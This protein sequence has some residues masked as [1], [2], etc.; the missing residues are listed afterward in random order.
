MSRRRRNAKTALQSQ[1]GIQLST[2]EEHFVF[3]YTKD[4]DHRRA[5]EV[6]GMHPDKG[7]ELIGRENV[8]EAV[9]IIYNMQMQSSELT[10]ETVKEEMYML[11]KL[12]LQKGLYSVA[13]KQLDQ[14]ARHSHIDAY[15]AQKVAVAADAEVARALAD[16][17][18]R[19]QELRGD[20]GGDEVS[21]L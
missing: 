9:R 10:A 17:R 5:A 14:L 15:A 1:T 11:Y 4:Y 7:S 18:K 3:E 8:A 13:S 16:G 20:A 21:F 2:D 6:V 19:L 12:S